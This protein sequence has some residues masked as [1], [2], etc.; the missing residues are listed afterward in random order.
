MKQYKASKEVMKLIKEAYKLPER[1]VFK[2]IRKLI[3]AMILIRKE[4]N[5]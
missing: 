2:A 3:K 1:D 5:L 4:A